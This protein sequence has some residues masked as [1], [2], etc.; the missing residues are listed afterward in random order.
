[1]AVLIVAI[2]A[3]LGVADE[4]REQLQNRFDSP[5]IA[6][7]HVTAMLVMNQLAFTLKILFS[8]ATARSRRALGTVLTAT[9]PPHG[10]ISRYA[11]LLGLNRKS[12]RLKAAMRRRNVIFKDWTADYFVIQV[13]KRVVNKRGEVG[14]VTAVDLEKMTCSVQIFCSDGSTYIKDFT[15]KGKKCMRVIEPEFGPE[16]QKL[17]SDP[18]AGCDC[19]SAPR[20]MSHKWTD[21][22]L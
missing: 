21:E 6:Q 10:H 1:M 12:L 16:K 7:D 22:E 3:H 11:N 5:G 20:V 19:G 2:V 14:V 13:G 18:H 9:L 15:T 17:R 8:C 4:V